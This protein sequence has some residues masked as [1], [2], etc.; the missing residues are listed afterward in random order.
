MK[1]PLPQNET[2][3]LDVLRQYNILDT[4][5]E[6]IFDE[7]T[8]LAGHICGTPVAL[9]TLID[10]HRQWNKSKV[11]LD[12]EET[13]RDASFCA[14][15]I[16]QPEVMVVPNSLADERFVDNPLVM[17]DPNIRFYAGTPLITHEGYA[18]GSLCVIDYQPRTL[19]PEQLDALRILGRQVVSQL[20]LRRN[21]QTLANVLTER[22]EMEETLKHVSHENS[23]LA[24]AIN[25]ATIGITIRDTTLPGKPFIFANPAFTQLTGY[26]AEDVIGRDHLFLY[27]PEIDQQAETI[28][29]QALAKKQSATVVTWNCRKD[30]TRFTN[31]LTVSPVLDET[32]EIVNTV[33]FQSDVTE[34]E[35]ARAAQAEVEAALRQAV[36]ENSQ[37][38]AAVNSATIGITIADPKQPGL[39]FTFINPAFT[40]LSGYRA[41]EVVGRSHQFLYGPEIDHE[42]EA[43]IGQALSNKQSATAVTWNCR[44]D[45]TRF[46]IELTLSPVLDEAGDMVSVV[47]FQTDVTE[48][49]AARAEREKV[50]EALRQSA[51]ENSQL[52]A[53]VNSATIGIAISD[54][55]KPGTPLIFVNPAFTELF[56]YSSEE[57]IGRN[58]YFLY[59]PE[60]DHETEAIIGRALSNKQPV[61]AITW[62]YRKDGTRLL[63]ELTVSPVFDEAGDIV[64]VV[65][66]QTDVTEREA[67]R[68]EVEGA[69]RQYVRREWD[70]LL[71][72]KY[73]G[74]LQVEYSPE[75]LANDKIV[76][77]PPLNG[78]HKNDSLAAE[79]SALVAKPN[80]TSLVTPLKLRGEVIGALKLQ[81]DASDRQWTAEEMA[82]VETVS[83]QLSQ[84]IENLR[85]FED[86][87]QR[88]T[89]EQLTRQITDKMRAA[90]NIETIIETGLSELSKVLGVSR[91]Y[92]KLVR[93]KKED[94]SYPHLEVAESDLG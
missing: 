40:E 93:S 10:A 64:S 75:P 1:A 55:K 61:T 72:E 8:R 15:T 4:P 24:A 32:G 88:A 49:E 89:R 35:A 80:Q 16:L 29:G 85:L 50:E 27:G 71:H 67:A 28:M 58:H 26:R 59:G 17:G 57:V 68:A 54:S 20:E 87:Q 62:N 38:A 48:R 78:T 12:V 66:F 81:D 44:K 36:Q 19:T 23:Q 37:L 46:L 7:L 41:E 69:Y 82:L 91:T 77:H 53:A 42:T 51:Q 30:G 65:S 92:V 21:V 70:Q 31:E 76:T 60:I 84:T 83:E 3:R 5:E 11:G 45:G 18:L 74:R 6:E 43:I 47:A 73:G 56:G 14:Y 13:P 22:E 25:S 86:T 33:A 9:V 94:Q 63:I 52:A 39:P 34:R 90:P 2:S 79:S